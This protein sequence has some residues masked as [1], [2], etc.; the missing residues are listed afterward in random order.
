MSVAKAPDPKDPD[1]S[2]AAAAKAAEAQAKVK[3]R[4]FNDYEVK[5]HVDGDVF[6]FRAGDVTARHVGLLRK[7]IDTEVTDPV[8]YALA[9]LAQLDPA[10]DLVAQVVYLARLQAG[11]SP[12]YD[13][14]ADTLTAGTEMWLEFPESA[15]LDP[16]VEGPVFLDPPA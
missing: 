7:A 6:S 8:F 13:E 10:A 4:A 1:G 15:D 2:K 11:E 3:A 12:S 5:L 14:I 16:G 9:R